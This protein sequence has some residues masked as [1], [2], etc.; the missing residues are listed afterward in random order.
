MKCL[1]PSFYCPPN[2]Q[3]V[4]YVPFGE[5]FIEELSS[6]ASWVVDYVVE[7]F[8]SVE[9]VD[10]IWLIHSECVHL[11]TEQNSRISDI[12]LTLSNECGLS[13]YHNADYRVAH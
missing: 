3:H 7:R 2:S 4:E 5:V 9:F 13:T 11:P 12:V 6:S 1:L 8:F 10:K